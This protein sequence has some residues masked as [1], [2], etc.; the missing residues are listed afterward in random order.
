[1]ND[2]SVD[3]RGAE[4]QGGTGDRQ[5]GCCRNISVAVG[6]RDIDQDVTGLCCSIRV[7]LEDHCDASI[8]DAEGLAVGDSAWAGA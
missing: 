5:L 1:M 6:L 7:V 4:G 2:V 3:D 8:G